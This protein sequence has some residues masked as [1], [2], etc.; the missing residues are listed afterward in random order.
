MTKQQVLD[1]RWGKIKKS[2]KSGIEKWG[3]ILEKS[4]ICGVFDSENGGIAVFELL[5]GVRF[6]AK[7]GKIGKNSEKPGKNRKKRDDLGAIWG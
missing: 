5:W 6:G 2:E 7:L 3:R 4:E 1:L